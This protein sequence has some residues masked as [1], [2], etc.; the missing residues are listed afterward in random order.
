MELTDWTVRFRGAPLGA[1]GKDG[2]PVLILYEVCV[3]TCFYIS[4]EAI[5]V[6]TC[7]MAVR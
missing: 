4:S 1:E 7:A 3:I 2:K 5:A 6:H